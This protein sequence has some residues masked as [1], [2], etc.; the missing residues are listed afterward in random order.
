LFPLTINAQPVTTVA[1]GTQG[2]LDGTGTDA[3]FHYPSGVASGIYLY[4]I[5]SGSGY[6]DT[7]RMTLLK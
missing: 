2:F 6:V 4:R 7:Q 1:G 3:K 5:V